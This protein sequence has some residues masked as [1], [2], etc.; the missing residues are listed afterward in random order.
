MTDST[1]GDAIEQ[2][3]RNMGMVNGQNM[4][5]YSDD[6]AAAY[7]RRAHRMIVG[8]RDWDEMTIKR[9][10]TLDG[11]TGKITQLITDTTD[12]KDIIRIYAQGFMT[13]L[14]R[15]SSYANPLT[16]TLILGYEGLAPENDA[17]GTGGRYLVQFQP[18]TLTG[19][20]LFH[21]RRKVDFSSRDVIL[22]VDYDWHVDLASWLWAKD[23]G[24]NP[25]QIEA[26][27]KLVRESK[28]DAMEREN[29]RPSYS[30][31]NQLIPNDWWVDD[32]YLQ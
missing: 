18:V 25:V 5:P 28:G 15:I 27:A 3:A 26:F 19:Q 29:K 11:T 32:G 24:T 30:N 2:V 12:W 7:V 31:P 10:R 9:T 1:Y 8:T 17:A 16:S 14:G 20:V 21:I 23:D 13:P 6:T 22:P 4:T